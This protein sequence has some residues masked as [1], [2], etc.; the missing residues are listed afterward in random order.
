MT[1]HIIAIE[2]AGVVSEIQIRADAKSQHI[3]CD[4]K[5]SVRMSGRIQCVQV[6]VLFNEIRSIIMGEKKAC[7]SCALSHTNIQGQ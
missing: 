3:S 5:T 1:T 4:I 6:K 2:Q 7:L